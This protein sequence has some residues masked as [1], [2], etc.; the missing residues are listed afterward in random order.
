MYRTIPSGSNSVQTEVFST[1]RILLRNTKTSTPLISKGTTS[2]A[3]WNELK[4]II[5]FWIEQGVL[6]FRVDNPHTKPFAFW[7]WVIY[8]VREKHPEIIFLS[9]AFTRPKIMYQLAK[10][11][12]SQ[13]YTYFAWRNTKWELTEYFQELTQTDVR[14]YFRPNAWPNTPDILTDYLQ[15]GGP[16]AFRTRLV[17]AATLSAN[18]GI[19]GPAYE[20]CEATPREPNSEEYL[21]AEKYEI[22]S[23]DLSPAESFRDFIARSESDQT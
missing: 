12:F 7:E 21:N 22:K 2:E 17:L 5:E 14:D 20:L 9:E 8:E 1:P 15:T 3:L 10:L 18:Y 19:Y 4:S 13:S 11:G 6:I 16:P 23:W